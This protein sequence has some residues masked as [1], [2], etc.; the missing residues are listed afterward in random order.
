MH[1]S[2]LYYIFTAYYN[3]SIVFYARHYYCIA[4]A[5]KLFLMRYLTF[6]TA[7][8]L[9]AACHNVDSRQG[10]LSDENS[11]LK[12]ENDSLKALLPTVVTDTLK[13]PV[14]SA[15]SVPLP[16]PDSVKAG[17]HP[18]T[19]QWIGWDKPGQAS[20]T[21]LKDGWYNISGRQINDKKE[22]LKIE[23]KIRR[24]SEKELEFDGTVETFV[25]DN[26]GGKPCIKKG[27]QHFLAKGSR[28]YFRMENMENCAGGNLVDYID[29]YPGTS[30]L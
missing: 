9:L 20:V 23:G 12:Q 5:A 4:K 11:R 30:S 28:T 15:P 27:T 8:F 7:L 10:T 22:Y 18:I 19:L 3:L 21:P 24:A 29:I 6:L 13:V 26:N 17:T 1:G 25:Q 14:T 16:P 2:F